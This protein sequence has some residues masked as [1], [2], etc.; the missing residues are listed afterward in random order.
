MPDPTRDP[1]GP[2]SPPSPAPVPAPSAGPGAGSATSGNPG[3]A[4]GPG[5]GSG[6]ATSSVP[7]EA[8]G[9]GFDPGLNP[10]VDPYPPPVLPSATADTAAVTAGS[11]RAAEPAP[12]LGAGLAFPLQLGPDGQLLLNELQAHVRQSIRLIL[13]TS[14]G[15]R[16]MRPDFGAG[17]GDLVFAP[18]SAATLALVQH[19]VRDALV[20]CEPRIDVLAVDV[21]A[22]PDRPQQLTVRL[23]YRV[24]RTDTRL[25]LV[26]PYYLERGG[27]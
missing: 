25:N 20:R 2:T 13:D 24:R 11:D 9:P 4:I 3:G 12:F 18:I 27:P 21:S 26:Y 14:R 7:D 8:P 16:L 15:E 19:E 22:E 17:L 6:S 10:E 23:D 5:P 1:T